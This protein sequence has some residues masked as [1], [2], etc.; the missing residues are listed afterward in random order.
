MAGWDIGSHTATHP[1]LTILSNEQITDELVFSKAEIAKQ[2]NREV[3]C[4]AYPF[5]RYNLRVIKFAQKAGYQAGFVLSNRKLKIHRDSDLAYA[6]PRYGVY[7][8]DT[9]KSFQN[10]LTLSKVEGAKQRVISFF[11]IGTIWHNRLKI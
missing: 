7:R 6:I 10:K 8:I 3:N 2:L 4:L 9:K 1:D 11:S 5:S